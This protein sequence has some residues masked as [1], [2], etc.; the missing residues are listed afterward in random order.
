[1][2]KSFFDI[3][4]NG[5]ENFVIISINL[6]KTPTVY[7]D[8]IISRL[9]AE[10]PELAEKYGIDRLKSVAGAGGGFGPVRIID[11]YN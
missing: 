11:I 6:S 1:M 5:K 4:Q 7:D 10:N 9:T 2:R 3:K 8:K